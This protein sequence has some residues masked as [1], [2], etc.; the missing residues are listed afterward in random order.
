M[1]AT[2]QGWTGGFL[3]GALIFLTA[4]GGGGTS[5][6][7]GPD[8]PQDVQI[9]VVHASPDAPRVDVY[10]EGLPGPVFTLSYLE[11]S[12]YAV[13]PEG[14]YNFQIFPENADP[15]VEA[16]AFETGELALDGGQVITAIAAGLLG[17]APGSDDAFR[18]LPF[19]EDFDP[20]GADALARIVHAG[21]DAPTVAVDLGDDGVGDAFGLQRFTDT[22]A[23]GVPLPTGQALQVAL[24]LD[25]GFQRVTAFTTPELTAGSE[26]FV[27]A[28]GLLGQKPQAPEGFGLLV[29][30]PTG[31]VG[32][33]PQNPVVYGVHASP[34]TGIVDLALTGSSDI[35]VD[36]LDFGELTP[37]LQVPAGQAYSIDVRDQAGNVALTIPTPVLEA[38]RRY[39]AIVTGYSQGRTPALQALLATEDF[40]VDALPDTARVIG[41]HASPDAGLVDIGPVDAGSG[42]VIALPGWGALDY[43]FASEPPAGTEIPTAPIVVGIAP[44]GQPKPLVTFDVDLAEENRA[45]AI[46]IGTVDTATNPGDQGIRILVVE[47]ATS[48]WQSAVLFPQTN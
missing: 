22:G 1:R 17:S 8:Q 27:I 36:D 24:L 42:D 18:V 26:L 9:R 29:V 33:L 12:D 16:P 41:V 35:L 15:A 13:L 6:D 38:G 10:V 40:E 7:S 19:V 30:A 14:S 46:V 31:T 2:V 4:C 25:P 39:L 45:W 47:T 23:A 48:P 43:G 20:A 21:A 5:G 3:V 44:T 34:N 28:T 11:S 37:P 32:F